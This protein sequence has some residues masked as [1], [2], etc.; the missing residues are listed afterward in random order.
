MNHS[1]SKFACFT[2]ALVIATF[3][4]AGYAT[5]GDHGAD[6]VTGTITT[7]NEIKKTGS[8][9]LIS[10]GTGDADNMTIRARQAVTNAD[11]IFTMGGRIDYY[12]DL[13]KGKEI[14]NAGH[15][16]YAKNQDKYNPKS[17]LKDKKA[18][19][20][21]HG[22]RWHKSP[23]E[24]AA[25]QE[26]TRQVIRDAVAAGKH[27][28]IIDNGD[29]TIFG[30]HIEYMREFSDLHP[31]IIPGISSF[32]AAN[33]VLQT[34]MVAGNAK[35]ITLTLGRLEN[36][37]DKM[38]ANMIH[39]GQTLVFFMVRDLNGFIDGLN[40]LVPGDTPVAI[41]SWA[42]SRKKQRVIKSTMGTIL[43]TIGQE[44]ISNYLLYVG[45]ALK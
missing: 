1:R 44:R 33:A 8:L 40:P 3:M 19:N 10:L 23:E 34:S 31:E 17:G 38:I 36:G 12:G 15:K 7:S 16:L 35:A 28:A 25:M 9:K 4:T 43:E 32:N 41:V 5:S 21:G 29:P 37:R 39:S 22:P 14:Y 45:T 11:I 42:G 2:V 30:P 26:K 6:A 13:L 20:T 24:L 18:K 27:V